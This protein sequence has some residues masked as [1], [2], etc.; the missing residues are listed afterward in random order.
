MRALLLGRHRRQQRRLPRLHTRLLRLPHQ[1]P[2]RS[3]EDTRVPIFDSMGALVTEETMHGTG[4]TGYDVYSVE[5][6]IVPANGSAVVDTGISVGF[7]EPGYWFLIAPRSGL[8]FKHGLQPHIGTV[9]NG[10]RGNCGVK[11]YNFSALNY[12]IKKGDRIA[13][14][15]FFPLI[16]AR[17]S[18]VDE[19]NETNRGDTGF[20]STGKA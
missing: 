19:A 18:W 20:G 15:I 6:T 12:S 11:L 14:L 8:G 3:H 17:V 4:D 10:Y 5:D 9:D 16:A 7:I 13:Q 1:L 2:R